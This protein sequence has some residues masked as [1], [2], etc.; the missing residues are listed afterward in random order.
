MFLQQLFGY[1]A[2]DEEVYSAERFTIDPAMQLVSGSGDLT[3]M[4]PLEVR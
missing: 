2:G 1:A 3:I 4:L